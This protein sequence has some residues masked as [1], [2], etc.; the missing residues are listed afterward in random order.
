M[1]AVRRQERSGWRRTPRST[2]SSLCSSD[3]QPWGDRSRSTHVD[4]SPR[5]RI[6]ALGP[7]TPWMVSRQL[8]LAVALCLRPVGLAAPWQSHQAPAAEGRGCARLWSVACSLTLTALRPKTERAVRVAIAPLTN[9][10]GGV[11]HMASSHSYDFFHSIVWS[12]RVLPTECGQDPTPLEL[13]TH[14]V[15][16]VVLA[17]EI[18]PGFPESI[19]RDFD[20]PEDGSQ[21]A[22][23][24]APKVP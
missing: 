7:S 9:R 24:R 23:R 16:T 3:D 6:R 15:V 2:E 13:T 21:A 11:T 12:S 8:L 1:R 20:G 19:G 10:N 4:G 22:W 17:V 14:P 18:P 5:A